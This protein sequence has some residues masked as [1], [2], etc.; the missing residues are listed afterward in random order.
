MPLHQVSLG[1]EVMPVNVHC[2]CPRHTIKVI[3]DRLKPYFLRLQG[4][5]GASLLAAVGYRVTV[6]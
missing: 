5:N 2:P 6:L 3:S 1:A 4:V